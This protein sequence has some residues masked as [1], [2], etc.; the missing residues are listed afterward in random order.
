MFLFLQLKDFT[1]LLKNIGKLIHTCSLT[2]SNYFIF[3]NY[4][5]LKMNFHI[6]K[7]ASTFTFANVLH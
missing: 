2:F 7:W 1:L 4:K 3:H 5:H 6:C